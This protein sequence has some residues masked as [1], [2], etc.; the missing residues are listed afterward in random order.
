MREFTV[1]SA[2]ASVPGSAV[3][4]DPQGVPLHQLLP[5][6][7]QDETEWQAIE[8]L[9]DHTAE[10]KE[11][12]QQL[13]SIE[14]H[15][16]IIIDRPEHWTKAI[17]LLKRTE[18]PEQDSPKNSEALLMSWAWWFQSVEAMGAGLARC[19]AGFIDRFLQDGAPDVFGKRTVDEITRIGAI[20]RLGRAGLMVASTFDMPPSLSTWGK[21]WHDSGFCKIE[22]A[23]KTV[24]ALMQTEA[25]E[26]P[27]LSPWQAFSIIMPP[28]LCDP[29]RRLWC[30]ADKGGEA[31]ILSAVED[32]GQVVATDLT[33]DGHGKWVTPERSKLLHDFMVGT[34]IAI[35]NGSAKKLTTGGASLSTRDNSKPP[36][37]ERWRISAPVHVDLREVVREHW[38]ANGRATRR[39]LCSQFVVRGHYRN[40]ACGA[41]QKDR[42]RIWIHPYMKGDPEAVAL[43][44]RVQIDSKEPTETKKDA[45]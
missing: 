43:L 34:I 45:E 31:T 17:S 21:L 14:G 38:L 33:I 27:I 42:K 13:D 25:P 20:K 3:V 9:R 32:T 12:L 36:S 41:G 18:W 44:R 29:V 4:V 5:Q 26:D 11:W 22:V 40:Q 37:C 6:E 16:N 24:A 2:F 10:V 23:P 39:R 28:G 15:P 30:F 8:W 19:Y 7:P 35:H 1:E